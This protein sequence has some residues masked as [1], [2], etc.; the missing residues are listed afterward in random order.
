MDARA[1]FTLNP[2]MHGL[3]TDLCAP[4]L[5][6]ITPSCKMYTA[7]VQTLRFS[8][9]LWATRSRPELFGPQTTPGSSIVEC[10]FS[11]HVWFLSSAS[12]CTLEDHLS[13]HTQALRWTRLCM[14]DCG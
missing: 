4:G 10:V 3:Y 1:E 7:A 8:K 6:V 13:Y 2:H 5:R 9:R 11:G 12:I 14:L